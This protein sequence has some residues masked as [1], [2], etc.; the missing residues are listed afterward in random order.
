MV[1]APKVTLEIRSVVVLVLKEEE[2]LRKCLALVFI[3]GI[4]AQ[5]GLSRGEG[6]TFR[7]TNWGMTA[8]EVLASESDLDPIEKSDSTIR[9]KTRV[10]GKNVE[11][12]YRFVQNKLI[13]S[14][15]QIDE[16]YLNSKHFIAGYRKFQE[17]LTQKYGPPEI[18]ETK[19]QKDTLPKVSRNEG[20]ALS[21]GQ[22]EYYSAWNT[23]HTTIA[24]SLRQDNY[25]VICSVSYR[26]KEF[27]ALEQKLDT[28][29]EI[30]P[31]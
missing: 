13:R 22:V 1:D 9:F 3:L 26:S 5:S 30:D 24:C 15:Y 6:Y 29:N 10:L 2:M 31:L 28:S 7:H 18:E 4:S 27:A 19:W 21:L 12:V 16:N 8:E 11:L 23:P 20:L 25:D 14:S 17:A